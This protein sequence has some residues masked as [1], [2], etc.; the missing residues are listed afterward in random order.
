MLN[1][2]QS[3]ALL[4]FHSLKENIFSVLPQVFSQGFFLKLSSQAYASL[5]P[6]VGQMVFHRI[7]RIIRI[8]CKDSSH[9]AY[10]FIDINLIVR[11]ESLSQRDP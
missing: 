2:L 10:K 8:E 6:M 7:A 1:V 3:P 5:Q 4:V 9:D 11:N